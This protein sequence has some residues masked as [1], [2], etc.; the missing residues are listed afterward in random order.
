MP[1][2]IRIGRGAQRRHFRVI[3]GFLAVAGR[4]SPAAAAEQPALS[5]QELVLSAH[6]SIDQH[7][8]AFLALVC[9]VALFAVVTTIMLART[10]ARAARLAAWAH[11]EIGRLRGKIDRANAL[12]FSEPQVVVD[13]PAGSDTPTVEG[14]PS[15]LGVSASQRLLAFGSWLDAGKASTV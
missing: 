8:I 11:D 4:I 1:G 12:M 14:D 3:A 7:E 9:G 2:T 5:L 6:R 15:A 10:R 13:W